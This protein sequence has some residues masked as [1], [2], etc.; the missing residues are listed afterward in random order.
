ML[1]GPLPVEPVE[2][3]LERQPG[4]ALA[5]KLVLLESGRGGLMVE[6]PRLLEHAR[7]EALVLETEERALAWL[8]R[9]EEPALAEGALD[10]TSVES[11]LGVLGQ[12]FQDA[13]GGWTLHAGSDAAPCPIALTPRGAALELSS[14]RSGLPLDGRRALRALR[15][16]AL[17]QSRRQVLVRLSVTPSGEDRASATWE[18]FVPSELPLER[19]LHTAVDALVCA[20]R[21]SERALVALCQAHPAEAFLGLR[22]RRPRASHASHPTSALAPAQTQG[23]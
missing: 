2:A 20:R 8:E 17:E 3:A 7:T 15:R 23:G 19:A 12:S 21:N 16:Y 10:R 6:I 14:V 1:V 13:A 22:A 18:T 5:A 4:L 9:G 11:A